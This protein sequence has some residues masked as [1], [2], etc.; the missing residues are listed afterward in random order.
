[1]VSIVTS[2]IKKSSPAPPPHP[3]MVIHGCNAKLKEVK[4]VARKTVISSLLHHRWSKLHQLDV[5][6]FQFPNPLVLKHLR[7][8]HLFSIL[9]PRLLPIQAVGEVPRVTNSLVKIMEHLPR[10]IIPF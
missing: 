5:T 2:P 9:Y 6:I 7:L 10:N 4:C 3:Y 1:M 8:P